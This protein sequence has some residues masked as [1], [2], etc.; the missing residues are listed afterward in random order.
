MSEPELFDPSEHSHRRRNPLTGQWVLVSPH[1]A[2]R[3]WQGAVEK[4]ADEQMPSHDPSC[5]LCAGNQRVTGER[6]P[7]YSGTFVFSNDFAA[8]MR[9]SSSRVRHPSK[10]LWRATCGIVAEITG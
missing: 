4:T 3:P 7:D 9:K 5:Y 8:L 10:G 1:R 6:N 2:K